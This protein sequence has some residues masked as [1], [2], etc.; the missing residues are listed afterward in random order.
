MIPFMLI[1]AVLAQPPAESAY[2]PPNMYLVRAKVVSVTPPASPETRTKGPVRGTRP[3]P[4]HS[5]VGHLVVTHVYLGPDSLR[6]AEFECKVGFR[7]SISIVYNG[8]DSNLK[9]VPFVAKEAEGLWWIYRDPKRDAYVPELR[10]CVLREFHVE[11]F[12]VQ[13]VRQQWLSLGGGPIDIEEK[14]KPTREWA[15]TVEKLYRAKS[16]TDRATILRD[17]SADEESIAA[18]WAVALLGRAKKADDIAELKRIAAKESYRGFNQPAIDEVLCRVDPE[19]WNQSETRKRMI[20]R[21]FDGRAD[22]ILTSSGAARLAAACRGEIDPDWYVPTIEFALSPESKLAKSN[23]FY[24]GRLLERTPAASPPLR[25]QLFDFY[26]KYVN[27][28]ASEEVRRGAAAGLSNLANARDLT[29]Q[30]RMTLRR[31]RDQATDRMVIQEL[32]RAL[33]KLAIPDANE[34]NPCR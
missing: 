15:E 17:L 24:V 30:Q 9:N 1:A 22:G 34:Q 23:Y 5:Q 11:Y 4:R 10:N 20:R 31:L 29:S 12:P 8:P 28:S 6:G 13:K 3:A 25:N 14:F 2:I 16:D 21:W 18:P 32:D 26:A 7:E 27:F 33:K 19:N